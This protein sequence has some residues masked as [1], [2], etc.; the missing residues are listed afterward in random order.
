MNKVGLDSSAVIALLL[1]EKGTEIVSGCEGYTAMS[2]I[3]LAEVCIRLIE[4][5]V[6]EEKGQQILSSIRIQ[7]Y[8]FDV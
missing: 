2:A 7:I 3:N 4:I 8:P 5:G 6:T 1:N